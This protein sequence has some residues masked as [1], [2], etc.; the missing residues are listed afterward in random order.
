MNRLY[1]IN[2]F[3]NNKVINMALL[4]FISF[5][6][7]LAILSA[8]V[9]GQ[10]LSTINSM[11]K[12]AKA[13]H[14]VQMHKG[15]IEQKEIDQF[16]ENYDGL[17]Y[18]QTCTMID[19]YGQ[20]ITI[21]SEE[22]QYNL[23]DCRIDIGFVKQNESKDLLLNGDHEK[24]EINDGE[25][26]MPVLLKNM[27]HLKIGDYV[28]L[29]SNGVKKQFV[30]KEFILDSMMNSTMCSSTRILI[31]DND[32]DELDGHVG[33]DEY[34][35]EAYFDNTS[36]A[37][38]FKAAYE[39]AGLPQNGQAVTYSMIFLL[40]A[41]TDL[42][43]VFGLVLASV[44]LVAIS[45]ICIKYTVMA[46]LEEE[47]SEIG[48][49][50]A[51]GISYM[52]IVK[53]YYGKYKALALFGTFLGYVW[54]LLINKIF[55]NHIS[56]TFG[57]IKMSSRTLL[58]GFIVG[59]FIYGAITLYCKRTLKVIKKLTVID[60]CVSRIG[61]EKKKKNV[62]GR[63]VKMGFIPPN[64]GIP[65]SE[66]CNSFKNWRIIFL[67]TALTTMLLL[68]PINLLNTI[69]SPKFITYMGSSVNDA[70]IEIED[71]NDLEKNYEKALNIITSDSSVKDVSIMRRV[72]VQTYNSENNVTNIHIDCGSFA[73]SGL[74]YLSGKEPETKQQIAISYLNSKECNKTT[75]D[76]ITILVNG[77]E[78]ILVVS[79]VYQD[80]TSGGYTAKAKY[81]FEDCTSEKYTF[82]VNFKENVSIEEKTKCWSELMGEG[83]SVD[84]MNVFINQTLG[85]VTDQFVK[86]VIVISLVG[87]LLIVLVSILFL[88]LRLA[89]DSSQIEI[90]RAVGFSKRDITNH[91]LIK[92]GCV[93]L[94]GTVV[95]AVFTRVLGESV[96]NFVIGMANVGIKKISL[97]YSPIVSYIICPGAIVLLALVVTLIIFSL[98]KNNSI[99]L[100]VDE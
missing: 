70:L 75:G 89:K 93:S 62:K 81:T 99:M 80:V 21:S 17:T 8:L 77:K 36:K 92:M 4:I 86:V 30:I 55:T 83:I 56:T 67:V 95:G 65:V 15:D 43:T 31:S 78:E 90:Y 39:N 64:L 33:E 69:N 59:I 49:M 20:S 47:V 44:M 26:G 68:I 37:T 19:V 10:T 73:G 38:D 82:L 42:M 2:D 23:S 84:P 7:G 57:K 24:V 35:V 32:F 100:K 66:L 14:F 74:E 28:I 11:Y 16:M 87:G 27:Y 98:R 41:L 40:S 25:V 46:A 61:F 29:E 54:A 71:G 45:F 72:C 12:K 50:K 48:T 58:L 51:I 53:I 79:G 1:F 3:K 96:V 94:S 6:A 34:L 88:K 97:F 76:E 18:W 13:P 85:G 63:L 91:Y 9:A 22:K 5:A 52:D 60:A